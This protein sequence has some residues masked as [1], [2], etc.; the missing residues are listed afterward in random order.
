MEQ[1]R[2]QINAR[3]WNNCPLE[4]ESEVKGN[5]E[6]EP[7]FYLLEVDKPYL[8]NTSQI[9]CVVGEWNKD[10]TK[11]GVRVFFASGNSVWCDGDSG[12][13]LLKRLAGYLAQ[14]ERAVEKFDKASRK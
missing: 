7:S 10:K 1:E 8:I 13:S 3:I 12:K 6:I 5:I 9:E 14:K 2:E 4:V 11:Y